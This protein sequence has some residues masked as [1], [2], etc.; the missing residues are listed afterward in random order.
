MRVILEVLAALIAGLAVGAS[1]IYVGF[2]PKEAFGGGA[3]TAFV[4]YC[5]T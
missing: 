4:V 2:D 3:G 1:M 5:L